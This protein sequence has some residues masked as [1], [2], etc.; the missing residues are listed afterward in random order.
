[1][2]SYLK[3][4]GAR[5][6]GMASGLVC[7]VLALRLY[8]HLSPS[9]YGVVVVALAFI[10]YL[11]LLDGG[12]RTT[13]NRAMLAEQNLDERRRLLH[14]GQTFYSWL[15][16]AVL[17]LAAVLMLGY[18]LTP[19]GRSSGQP[20]VFFLSL[21]LAGGISV[22]SS[23][24]AGVLVGLQ[25]QAAFFALTAL[26]SW[27]SLVAL[28][29]VLR[30]GGGV[31]AFPIS[32]IAGVLAAYP[33]ALW[34]IK[35]REPGMP[36]VQFERGAEF[37]RCFT[38]LRRDAWHCFQSQV[39]IV[40]LYTID[41]ILVGLLCAAGDAAI[42]AILSRIFAILRGFLQAMSE[43]SWPIIAQRGS[44]TQQLNRI[45]N[46]MNAWAVGS[47][48]GALY[49]TLGPFCQWF[50]GQ[51]WAAA[52]ALVP[53]YLIGLLAARFLITSLAAPAAYV[54]Y[55]SGDFR[56]ISRC[57]NREL[58]AAVLGAIVLGWRFGLQGIALAFVLSTVFG[59]LYPIF[60][61]YGNKTG[62]SVMGTL[63]EIW[64]RAVAGLTISFV[65]TKLTL[66]YLAT[67]SQLVAAGALGV[68]GGLAACCAWSTVRMMRA[69]ASV[70]PRTVLR[71]I[72]SI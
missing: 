30:Q 39:S 17:I 4:L 64:L 32:T 36:I 13:I 6:F 35:Q 25:A 57:L 60:R 7:G 53:P 68:A 5:I 54:L 14:F 72:S 70:A 1:M 33:T 58:A 43:I 67:G 21:A 61:A 59:T 8:R 10:G 29:F 69:S 19:P 12:F 65:C 48:T 45:V 27:V 16:L 34:L 23:I 26:G 41:I 66:N 49:L 51:G 46:R 50:M 37:H 2:S 28:W 56:G 9:A 55:G 22:M 40:V 71:F 44:G 52:W 20:L 38:R 31:W 15:G 18:S 62:E 24:Q 11:P 42:Y 47:V 63:G 3:A